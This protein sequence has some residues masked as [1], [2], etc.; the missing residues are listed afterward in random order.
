MAQFARETVV[1]VHQLAVDDY[2]ASNARAERYHDEVF[3]A[4]GRPEKHF[5]QC[6][7]IGV[8][9]Q[10]GRQAEFVSYQCGGA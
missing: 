3:H 2:T 1:S 7:R 6:C 5:S 8:V 10:C 9:C 4:F